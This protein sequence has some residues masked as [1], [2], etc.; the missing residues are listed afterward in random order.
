MIGLFLP[1]GLL[2]AASWALATFDRYIAMYRARLS[3][4]RDAEILLR[5]AGPAHCSEFSG[6]L[7]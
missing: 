3:K 4:A 6:L 5:Q 7:S 1:I 2:L